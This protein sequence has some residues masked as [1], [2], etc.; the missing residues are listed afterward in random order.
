MREPM[1]VC[2]YRRSVQ[3]VSSASW[4]FIGKIEW[5]SMSAT[6]PWTILKEV[7]GV[8]EIHVIK[9]ADQNARVVDEVGAVTKVSQVSLHHSFHLVLP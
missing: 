7:T 1:K 3:V 5:V 4:L 9:S 8:K 2:I 6:W